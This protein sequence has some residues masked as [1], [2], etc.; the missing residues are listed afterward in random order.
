MA[1][2]AICRDHATRRAMWRAGEHLRWAAKDTGEVPGP[3]IQRI[4]DALGRE[5]AALGRREEAPEAPTLEG[6]WLDR[7]LSPT[8]HVVPVNSGLTDLDHEAP[9]DL[10]RG[11]VTIVGA[12]TSV[13]K[14]V[15]VQQVATHN[16]AAGLH[17]VL[18]SAEMTNEQLLA[19][20]KAAQTGIPLAR[21]LRATFSEAE[22]ST[23]RTTPL[24]PVRLYDK[25]GMTTADVNALVARFALTP[26]PLDLVVVD[27]LHHLADPV[28]RGETRY[29]QVGRMVAALKET[30]KRHGCV[31][32][33]AAQLNRDAQGRAPTLADLRDAG[34]IE[35]YASVVQFLH[36][37]ENTPTTCEVY[38]AKHR[39]GPV[40]KCK[41]YFD[42]PCVR[43]R[44]F[45]WKAAAR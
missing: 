20:A 23:L 10:P 19:R 45:D 15:F 2:H 12:R 31:L 6:P 13:G 4:L 28:E 27:H 37:P 9:G 11:E 42:A 7:L 3:A 41:L 29:V 43:F 34:T 40:G 38:V 17:V 32:L 16:A 24:P 1:V 33:V 26:R 44:D 5:T 36:R 18:C 35:E 8:E 39:N 22:I 30:A 14:S 21:I 25:A